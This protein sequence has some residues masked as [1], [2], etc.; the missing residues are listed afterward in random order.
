MKNRSLLVFGTFFLVL[1]LTT[2]NLGTGS[3]GSAVIPGGGIT[4]GGG[5]TSGGGGGDGGLISRSIK[6]YDG[7][8]AFIGYVIPDTDSLTVFSSNSYIYTLTWDGGFGLAPFYFTGTNGAGTM[9]YPLKGYGKSVFYYSNGGKLYTYKDLDANGVPQP[10]GTIT[11]GESMWTGGTFANST[12]P[13]SEA[14]EFR[15][16]TRTEAGIPA[17]FTL[18]FRLSFE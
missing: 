9:F 13:V 2:C 14:Y 18:P 10:N 11:Q 6:L 1:A 15:E 17:S 12:I 5:G 16:I 3:D 7:T 4:T 8:D